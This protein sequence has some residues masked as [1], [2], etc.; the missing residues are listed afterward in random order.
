MR[1]AQHLRLLPLLNTLYGLGNS[2]HLSS[3]SQHLT[4]SSLALAPRRL[5]ESDAL[6]AADPAKSGSSLPDRTL[7]FAKHSLEHVLWQGFSTWGLMQAKLE[8]SELQVKELSRQ[9]MALERA[10]V[11]LETRNR[12]L[13]S[14][15]RGGKEA[16]SSLAAPG[17]S[18]QVCRCHF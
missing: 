5:E 18:A 17:T 14:A 9:V 16:P 7:I 8:D 2:L 13:E 15:A 4:R 10:K 12:Q 3:L 6:P 11:E 1:R